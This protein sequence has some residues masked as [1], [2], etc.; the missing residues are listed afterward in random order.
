MAEASEKAI[1]IELGDTGYELADPDED[2]RGFKVVDQEDDEI[3]TVDDLVIDMDEKR[4]RFL[5]VGA[6][7]FL[8]IGE[9]R[10]MI[11]I[12]AVESIE[13]CIVHINQTRERVV[14]SPKYDPELCKD[15]RYRD[16]IYGYYGFTPYYWAGSWPYPPPPK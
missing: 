12:E 2:V 7:G 1:L 9:T 13:D 3:G 10:F 15:P 11:P 6:G 4:V 14:E 16:G 5:L 8:G